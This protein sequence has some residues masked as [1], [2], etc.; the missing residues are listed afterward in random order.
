MAILIVFAI[1]LLDL[2]GWAL[3]VRLLTSVDAQ[4]TSMRIITAAC[5]ALCAASLAVS[6]KASRGR[7]DSAVSMALAFAVALACLLTIVVYAF[8]LVAGRET[9]LCYAPALRLFL[10]PSHRMALLTAIIFLVIGS[11]LM[12]LATGERRAAETAHA[13]LLP[14]ACASYLIPIS[15]AFGIRIPFTSG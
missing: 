2:A 12:L 15:Y 1:S 13:L 10:A 3:N 5:L 11:V 14:A 7:Y 6:T 9:D 8:R 4:W